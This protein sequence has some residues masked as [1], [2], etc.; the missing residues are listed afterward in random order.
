MIIMAE[1]A[2]SSDDEV[3][4]IEDVLITDDSGVITE[5]IRSPIKQSRSRASREHVQLPTDGAS[6]GDSADSDSDE[7]YMPH[8]D[9]SGEKI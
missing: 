7:E 3:T 8:S 6:N 4:V 9:D 2:E 1:P 5:V